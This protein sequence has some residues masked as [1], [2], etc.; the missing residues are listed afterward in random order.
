M[1]RAMTAMTM[2]RMLM[3]VMM[4]RLIILLLTQFRCFQGKE[5][6]DNDDDVVWLH[7]PSKKLLD[8]RLKQV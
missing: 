7:H 1:T 8:Q 2:M 5:E 4:G 6:S 3:M